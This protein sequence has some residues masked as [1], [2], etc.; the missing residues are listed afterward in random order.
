[1]GSLFSHRSS[2][3]IHPVVPIPP[4]PHSSGSLGGGPPT[5][6]H[7][8]TSEEDLFAPNAILRDLGHTFVILSHEGDLS[9]ERVFA[10]LREGVI[11]PRLPS[12][13]LIQERIEVLITTY[14][15][16][17]GLS[18]GDFGSG[19]GESGQGSSGPSRRRA[20]ESQPYISVGS[21]ETKEGEGGKRDTCPI[22][23][24]DFVPEVHVVNLECSHIFHTLCIKEWLKRAPTCPS[25]RAP[26]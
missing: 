13:D 19:Q 23:L 18:F 20:L 9:Q 21:E 24:V 17:G 15:T 16:L 1:M 7:T 2:S 6:S 3:A 25:C 4:T 10:A 8:V 11:R 22:C 12:V 5:S 26:I 14:Q